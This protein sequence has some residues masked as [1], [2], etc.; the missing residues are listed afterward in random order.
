MP[1]QVKHNPDK[2]KNRPG[3]KRAI[4][5]EFLGPAMPIEEKKVHRGDCVAQMSFAIVCHILPF[6]TTP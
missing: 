6:Q 5:F 2:N 1:D 3:E 4:F